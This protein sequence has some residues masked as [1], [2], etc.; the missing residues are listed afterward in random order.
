MGEVKEVTLCFLKKEKG[1]SF[2]YRAAEK[3]RKKGEVK[4]IQEITNFAMTEY[5]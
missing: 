4:K 5:I 3:K 2:M 1:D